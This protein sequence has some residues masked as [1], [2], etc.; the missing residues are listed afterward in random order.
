MRLETPVVYF[1]P[2]PGR[3]P[4]EHVEVAAS[5]RGGWLS[6]FYPDADAQAPGIR[7]ETGE[8]GHLLASTV[9]ALAWHDLTVGGE[10]TGP[11]T[12]EHV[13][14][15]PRA[16]RAAAVQTADG[17]IERFLF[18]RGVAHIDAP[19]A[20]TR[21]AADGELTLESRL[22]PE[23]AAAAPLEV[24]AAWLVDVRADGAVAYRS[25]PPVRLPAE[26]R[27][28][29]R[30]SGRFAPAEYR[31]GNQERLQSAV[32]EALVAAG[33]YDDEARALLS[34]WE[35]GRGATATVPE[36]RRVDR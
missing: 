28:L 24:D 31:D 12:A 19:I 35:R 33:L 23:L 30:I 22:A 29:A 16:V 13:W 15:A 14:T 1:H 8:I 20:V 21:D 36:S 27:V 32:H 18:Y 26:R 2:S 7:R 17:E 34:T 10:V 5:F 4:M 6:E 9:G 3:P 11:A 25:M